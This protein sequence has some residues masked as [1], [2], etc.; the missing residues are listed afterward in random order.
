MPVTLLIDRHGRI[1]DAHVGMAVKSV[2][3]AEIRQ[4]L[5]ER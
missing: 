1:V 2:S 3:E 4:L 5:R